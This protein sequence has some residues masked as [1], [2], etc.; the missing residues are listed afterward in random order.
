MVSAALHS[1]TYDYIELLP[2]RQIHDVDHIYIDIHQSVSLIS[3]NEKNP[4]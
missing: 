2:G 4:D 1:T 3:I